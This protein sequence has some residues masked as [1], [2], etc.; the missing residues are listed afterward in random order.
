MKYHMKAIKTAVRIEMKSQESA[1]KGLPWSVTG[2]KTPGK[3][4]PGGGDTHG[5]HGTHGRTR[6]HTRKRHR[7]EPGHTRDTQAHTRTPDHTDEPHNHPNPTTHPHDHATAKTAADSTDVTGKTEA[8][9]DGSREVRPQRFF[10]IRAGPSRCIAT[11]DAP[12][13]RQGNRAH[14]RETVRA[15]RAA[16]G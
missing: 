12:G 15:A 1:R 10:T 9:P 14:A 4:T 13:G 6:A 2:K 3:K 8:D 11:P 5:T 16:A 7:G